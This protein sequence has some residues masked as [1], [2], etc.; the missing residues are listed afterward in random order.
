MKRKK[1]YPIVSPL[2]SAITPLG[3]VGGALP[4]CRTAGA[5]VSAGGQTSGICSQ[6]SLAGAKLVNLNSY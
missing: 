1:N 5:V 2:C 6:L 4:L 3:V